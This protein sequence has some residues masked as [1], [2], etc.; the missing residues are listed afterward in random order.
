M[1]S[2]QEPIIPQPRPLRADDLPPFPPHDK[3][4]PWVWNDP[5]ACPVAV[6]QAFMDKI[7]QLRNVIRLLPNGCSHPDDPCCTIKEDCLREEP[8][9]IPFKDGDEVPS[10]EYWIV[11]RARGEDQKRLGMVEEPFVDIGECVEHKQRSR[12]RTDDLGGCTDW[13][14]HYM[15]LIR[16]A[17][18]K[19]E[20]T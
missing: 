6:C 3:D 5:C 2:E 16:P 8:R 12:F 7:I 14:T 20:E 1:T 9:W 11:L 18:P 13:V 15:P 10:G 4:C 17:P 19:K